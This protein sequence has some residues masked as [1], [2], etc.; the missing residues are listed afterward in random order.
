MVLFISD[1][2]GTLL[3]S[4]AKVSKKSTEILNELAEKGL[5]FTVATARTPISALP[6]LKDVNITSPLILM[7]GALIYSPA[8]KKFS[9]SVGFG[10]KCMESLARAEEVSSMEGMLFSLDNSKF[11]VHLGSV[12]NIMWDGYFD[13]NKLSHIEAVCKE[14]KKGSAK[15]L[16]HNN[17]VYA[18][19]MDNKSEYIE[20]LYNELKDE[21]G[22]ILDYYK[23]KYTENRWCLEISSAST[24]K[25][26]AVKKLR[27][28]LGA[29][30]LIGFGDSWNDVPLFEG[31]DEGYAVENASDELKK[32]ATGIIKSNTED[33][34]ALFIKEWFY[35]HKQE[36][37]H[38]R[39]KI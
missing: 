34:V 7:N 35:K 3:D 2:D 37:N 16:I 27:E 13:L 11:Y 18:L 39:D 33:G 38:G 24:S 29:E 5:N 30:K 1:M 32:S 31:C 10:R 23:D 21:K 36:D 25:G 6:I 9:D 4:N 20:K 14:I 8:D 12:N 15:D 22:L 28:S 19:Y 26:E 17:V